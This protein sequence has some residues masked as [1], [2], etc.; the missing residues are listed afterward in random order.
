MKNSIT[1]NDICGVRYMI[2]DSCQYSCS[3]CA[4]NWYKQQGTGQIDTHK[5]WFNEWA[6][7]QNIHLI[8]KDDILWPEDYAF[9][10]SVFQKYY[11]TFD[12][13]LTGWEAF[14]RKEYQEITTS[15][16]NATKGSVI[17]TLTK[18]APLFNQDES[19]LV[20]FLESTDRVIV[21]LDTMDAKEHAQLNLP[22]KPYDIVLWWL[23][24]TLDVISKIRNAWKTV[25]LNTVIL[26]TDTNGEKI[27]K[28]IE[29]SHLL[30]ISDIKF[31]ELDSP[32]VTSPY[33]EEYFK[34]QMDKWLLGKYEIVEQNS[35]YQVW[36]RKHKFA[37]IK[38]KNGNLLSIGTCRLTCSHAHK[39]LDDIEKKWC[40]EMDRYGSF[41]INTT[42]KAVPC[43]WV[44]QK[45]IDLLS[46]IRNRDVN[47]LIDAIRSVV[48]QI[49]LQTCPV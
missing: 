2:T 37:S 18:G 35:E 39:G 28:I 9:L 45:Q 21:S 32:E 6:L 1:D 19:Y 10:S 46:Y 26:P 30:N 36:T 20:D 44:P 38:T 24:K 16:K 7:V 14:N 33:V 41:T 47:W 5:Y 17:T 22:L 31:L 11:G 48:R 3:H 49:E 34:T 42:W 4:V 15:I 23:D 25:V 29:F 12:F 27:W 43:I 8:K 13:T 40:E